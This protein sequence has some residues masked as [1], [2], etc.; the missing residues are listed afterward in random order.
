MSTSP[1][2]NDDQTTTSRGDDAPVMEEP[3]PYD[4]ATS[5]GPG[6]EWDDGVVPASTAP[7]AGILTAETFAITGLLAI[8][9]ILMGSQ[10]TQNLPSILG[11][12]QEGMLSGVVAADGAVSLFAVVL[13]V[14]SLILANQF[15]RPWARWIATATI[16]VGVLVI[17]VSATTFVL[18][19]EPQPQPPMMPSG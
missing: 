7:P 12:S 18:V 8:S 17:A 6:E 9:T 1:K 10:I 15:T 4:T 16:I 11:Q 2:S 13:G 3:A 19:P 5:D 14:V